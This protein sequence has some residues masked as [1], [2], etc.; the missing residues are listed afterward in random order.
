[1]I[2]MRNLGRISL[3]AILA[4]ACT[5]PVLAQ[6]GE[7]NAWQAIQDER[8]ARRRAELIESF[9]SRYPNSPQR[10]TVDFMLVDYYVANKDNAKIMQHAEGFR[11]TLPSADNPAKARIYTQAM[12]AAATLTNLPKTVEYGGYALQAD[13]NNLNV[14]M[15]LSANNLPDPAKALEYAQ[16]ALTVPRPAT[17]TEEQYASIQGRMH[18]VVANSL[19]AEQKFAEANEHFVAVLKANPKDHASHF[20]FGYGSVTLAAAK[21]N[22]A[23]AANTE[24]IKLMTATPNDSAA[25]NATKEKM[26]AASKAALTHRDEAVDAMAKAVAIGGQFATQAR[27][28]LD[29][30]YKNKTGSLDGEEEFIAQK[31]AELGL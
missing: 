30:L 1:M 26:E 31:K 6:G 5:L 15:F 22:E 17:M 18:G 2:G 24:L 4:L 14:L 21:A 10:P 29:S 3:A 28:L 20:R 9:V 12:I 8:D 27:Q 13:P 16:R 7:N 25:V 19:F 23:Q 11:L